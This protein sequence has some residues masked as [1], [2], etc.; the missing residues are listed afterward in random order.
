MPDA[1]T[2]VD[3]DLEFIEISNTGTQFASLDG[4]TLRH[5]SASLT[6]YNTTIQ[7]LLIAPESSVLLTSDSSSLAVYEDGTMYDISVV[8]NRTMFFSD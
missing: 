4:W 1:S 7:S 8:L 2:S 5:T 3:S 6:P